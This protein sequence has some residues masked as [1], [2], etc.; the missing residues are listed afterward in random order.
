MLLIGVLYLETKKSRSYSVFRM[1]FWF[2]S[3][4][5][6]SILFRSRIYALKDS[7]S[8]YMPEF[9]FFFL[10][11]ALIVIAFLIEF[12]PTKRFSPLLKNKVHLYILKLDYCLF[13]L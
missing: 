2:L 6:Y 9:I 5:S 11:Y 3:I 13:S 12:L 4:V 7:Q 10:M 8:D 1:L